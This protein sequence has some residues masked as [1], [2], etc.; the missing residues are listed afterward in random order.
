MKNK[1]F[2]TGR[3]GK[4][5]RIYLTIA[6]IEL[7]NTISSLTVDSMTWAQLIGLYPHLVEVGGASNNGTPQLWRSLREVLLQYAQL[8]RAPVATSE[9]DS[10]D[11]QVVSMV[12]GT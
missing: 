9:A 6:A 12:N 8:L 10:N 4:S 7:M 1:S 2:C 11:N 3:Q 5:N